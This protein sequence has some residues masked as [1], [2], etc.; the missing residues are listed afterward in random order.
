MVFL[1]LYIICGITLFHIF[2][3]IYYLGFNTES[4]VLFYKIKLTFVAGLTIMTI[5]EERKFKLYLI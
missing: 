5:Q 4:Y 3:I 2:V 1:F